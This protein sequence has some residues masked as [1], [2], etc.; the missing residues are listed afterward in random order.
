MTFGHISRPIVLTYCVGT[1]VI[2]SVA[3]LL[4]LL[5]N[6]YYYDGGQSSY[7]FLSRPTTFGQSVIDNPDEPFREYDD[8]DFNEL[9]GCYHVYL[10]VGSNIG[11]QVRKLYE[12]HLFINA[13]VLTIF[14]EFFGPADTRHLSGS[15]CAIGIEPNPHHTKVLE[16]IQSAY[17]NCGWKAKFHTTTAASH[18]YGLATFYSDE[19][20]INQEWGGSILKSRVAKKPAGVTK[21]IR[22]ADYILNKVVKRQLPS[23][24]SSNDLDRKPNVIM[25]LDIE[26]SELEV[27]TDLVVTGALQHLDLAFVEY[28]PLSFD[29]D[30]VRT[31]YIKGLAKA[32]DTINFLSKKLRLKTMYNVL[33]FDDESYSNTTFPLPQC[34]DKD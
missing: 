27:M 7:N 33:S 3:N 4:V 5:S 19:N 16:S 29:K 9:D 30:D 21:M 31:N 23:S 22:L 11:N 6:H 2:F 17:Q 20:L 25:K 24:L 18:S 8:A 13:S 1:L 14:E 32:V 26:G 15:V 10:D 12:P 28:H 34:G